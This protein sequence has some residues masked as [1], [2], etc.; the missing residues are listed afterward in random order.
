M[1]VTG[2]RFT[3]KKARFW[4]HLERTEVAFC[5]LKAKLDGNEDW[6]KKKYAREKKICEFQANGS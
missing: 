2:Y 5:L 6:M 3:L 1:V 4:K